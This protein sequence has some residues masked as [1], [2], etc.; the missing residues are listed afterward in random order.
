MIAAYTKYPFAFLLFIIIKAK[1]NPHANKLVINIFGV[2]T[3]QMCV[4]LGARWHNSSAIKSLRKGTETSK[5]LRSLGV[6]ILQNPR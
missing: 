6:R 3:I 4:G 5:E 2:D 1:Y